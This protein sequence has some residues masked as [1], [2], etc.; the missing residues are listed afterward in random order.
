MK[1]MSSA[2]T[3][4]AAMIRSPSFS[5]SSSSRITTISPAPMAA[6]MSSMESRPNTAVSVV[7]CVAMCFQEIQMGALAALRLYEPLEVASQQVHLNINS[8]TG[9]V[10]AKHRLLLGMRDNVDRKTRTAHRIHRQAHAVD[11]HRTFHCHVA[12]ERGRHLERNRQ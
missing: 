9:L 3:F 10:V 12:R 8:G 6:T 11:G 1:L 7:V 4:V 2:R 5:R